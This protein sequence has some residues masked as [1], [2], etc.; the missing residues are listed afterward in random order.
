MKKNKTTNLVIPNRRRI[1]KEQEFSC[2]EDLRYV[3]MPLPSIFFQ[4]KS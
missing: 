3:E 1:I 4:K 2:R